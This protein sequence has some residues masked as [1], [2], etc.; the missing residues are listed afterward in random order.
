MMNRKYRLAIFASGSGTNAERFF[1][2][3]KNSSQIE[4]V[5]LL[6]NNAKAFVLERAKKAGVSSKVF[7]K[8]QLNEGDVLR[9]LQGSGIT[10]IVLA[11]FLWLI[12]DNLINAYPNKIINIHPA[13]LPKYGGRGMYGSKVHQAVKAAGETETGITIHLVN[14]HY[15]EGAILFQAKTEIDQKDT[16]DE[17][18]NKVHQLEYKH[19]PVVTE[20]WI[21]KEAN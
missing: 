5:L 3:F 2:Y 8:Q 21:L 11:G 20:Q 13:L 1:S 14:Q 17:I 7:D 18:A 6:S 12:P 19:Y 15:D 9:W 4:I 10:H 16:P